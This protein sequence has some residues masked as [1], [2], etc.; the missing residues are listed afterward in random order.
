MGYQEKG[1]SKEIKSFLDLSKTPEVV[2]EGVYVGCKDFE[3]DF[4]KST[5]HVIEQG[6]ELIA[7]FGASD[8]NEKLTGEIGKKVRVQFADKRQIAGGRSLKVFKV[9]VDN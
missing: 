2:V 8:L 4:G 3:T 7:V 1:T 6:G 5:F 9:E